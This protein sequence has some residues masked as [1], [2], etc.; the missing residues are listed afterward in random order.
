MR[1]SNDCPTVSFNS[2]NT[3]VSSERHEQSGYTFMIFQQT[4]NFHAKMAIKKSYIPF[5][6]R[7]RK[8]LQTYLL[9]LL[10]H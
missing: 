3:F 2:V 1:H 8:L 4:I 10:L 7:C 5:N 9:F 6:E